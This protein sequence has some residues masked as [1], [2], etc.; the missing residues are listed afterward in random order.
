MRNKKYMVIPLIILAGLVLNA[1]ASGASAATGKLNT[2]SDNE[3]KRTLTLSGSGRVALTPDLARIS[4]GVHNENKNASEAIAANNKNAQAVI[5][6]LKSFGIKDK[7]ISTSNFSVYPQQNWG[8][9]G[10]RLGITYIVDNTVRV[11]VRDLDKIGKILDAVTKAGA[12][13]INGIQFD[14]TDRESAYQN[15]LAAAVKNARERAETIAKAAGV[16]LDEVLSINTYT[17]SPAPVMRA[18]AKDMAEAAPANE[19]PISAGE[20]FV[21]VTVNIVFS[22]K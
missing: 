22:L 9:E 21:N 4:I 10:E 1:C 7:D 11:T 16:S 8:K 15:A 5:K 19:V 6:A 12:N 3:N 13:N 17:N 20:M 18:Y 14:V 2:D